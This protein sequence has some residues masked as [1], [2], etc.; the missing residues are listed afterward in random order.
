M[1]IQPTGKGAGGRKIVRTGQSFPSLR[2]DNYHLP[3]HSVQAC[4][5]RCGFASSAWG[6]SVFIAGFTVNDRNSYIEC[7]S[8]FPE[9]GRRRRVFGWRAPDLD[10][11]RR[12]QSTIRMTA[13]PPKTSTRRADVIR[14]LNEGNSAEQ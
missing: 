2:Q 1:S 12:F 7:H 4:L 5:P 9:D 10:G 8:I 11:F 13:I 3:P 14:N 6:I